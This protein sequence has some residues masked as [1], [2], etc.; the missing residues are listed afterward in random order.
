[1]QAGGIW[2]AVKDFPWRHGRTTD[3]VVMIHLASEVAKVPYCQPALLVYLCVV[4]KPFSW[5]RNVKLAMP[6]SC[7]LDVG[8]TS[9]EG[10]VTNLAAKGRELSTEGEESGVCIFSGRLPQKNN[11]EGETHL[12]IWSLKY[13]RIPKGAQA[14]REQ[15]FCIQNEFW[16][17]WLLHIWNFIIKSI[18][19]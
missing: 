2:I 12:G 15:I 16:S 17:Y 9:R 13:L 1:M 5:D 14:P 3:S 19:E 10:R 18:R 11:W 6:W 8:G 7:F 4:K